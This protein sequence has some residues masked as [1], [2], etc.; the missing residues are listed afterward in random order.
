MFKKKKGK[1][2]RKYIE[3]AKDN[4]EQEDYFICMNCGRRIS[5][6]DFVNHNSLCKYC[7]GINTQKDFPGGPP[8][9]P[10]I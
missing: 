4:L 2:R 8:G 3:Q 9:F 6:Y 10:G 7:R 5:E 1:K